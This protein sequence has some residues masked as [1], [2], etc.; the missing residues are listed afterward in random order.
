MQ[1]GSS[2]VCFCLYLLSCTLSALV[3][4]F[5]PV[6][7]FQLLP[8]STSVLYSCSRFFPLLLPF[9]CCPSILRHLL[10]PLSPSRHVLQCAPSLA[11]CS[12]IKHFFL[13]CVLFHRWCLHGGP[14]LPCPCL[15]FDPIMFVYWIHQSCI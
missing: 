10:S 12:E 9:S 7:R 1:C 4:F 14:S 13:N 3:L 6:S 2:S 11:F 5:S 8:S 15:A